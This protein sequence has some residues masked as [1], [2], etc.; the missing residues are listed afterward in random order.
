MSDSLERSD[1]SSLESSSNHDYDLGQN[2][3]INKATETSYRFLYLTQR[4]VPQSDVS[5]RVAKG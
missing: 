3:R 5:C 2:C 4:T 1:L